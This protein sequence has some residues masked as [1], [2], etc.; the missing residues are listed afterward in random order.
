MTTATILQSTPRPLCVPEQNFGN[1]GGWGEILF[2]D[3]GVIS[4]EVVV[5]FGA[6][7]PDVKLVVG[8]LGVVIGSI[9]FF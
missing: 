1:Q 2:A 5:F 8:I 7:I 6:F 4:D 3:V 9:L